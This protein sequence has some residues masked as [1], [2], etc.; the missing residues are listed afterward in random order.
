V[1]RPPIK[2]EV[3]GEQ[4]RAIVC[5]HIIEEFKDKMPRGFVWRRDDAG[6]YEAL[7]TACSRMPPDL[8]VRSAASLAR[9]I[10]LE[11]FADAGR[12]NGIDWGGGG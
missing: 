4:R 6:E 11:C 7:C 3:H 9:S 1:S 12:R 2:C 10:C 8:W 5:E